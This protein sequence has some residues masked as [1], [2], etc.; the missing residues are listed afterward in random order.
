MEG[1]SS[2]A[3][4]VAPQ[5]PR[6]GNVHK[7]KLAQRFDVSF[8]ED[9]EI[10]WSQAGSVQKR[11]LL[12]SEGNAADRGQTTS[13]SDVQDVHSLW[14]KWVSYRRD[15]TL[16]G[17]GLAPGTRQTLEALRDPNRRPPLP[18]DPLPQIIREHQPSVSF[19]LDA[20][21]FASNLVSQTV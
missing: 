7:V 16:E 19:A 11:R 14:C 6:G 12:S 17:A 20:Q 1:V 13:S 8:K 5:P 15:A 3:P 10:C 18:R 21:R 9:G 2:V 4:I